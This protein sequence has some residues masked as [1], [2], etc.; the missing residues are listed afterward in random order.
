MTVTVPKICRHH[1]H[2]VLSCLH[3]PRVATRQQEHNPAVVHTSP[4]PGSAPGRCPATS[5]DPP[6]ASEVDTTSPPS[7]RG[8]LL[9]QRP[10][11]LSGTS[12]TMQGVGVGDGMFWKRRKARCLGQ[13]RGGM[14]RSWQGG[15]A[16]HQGLGVW[17][18][19]AECWTRSSMRGAD[20]GG[21]ED[22]VLLLPHCPR[23]SRAAL[24]APTLDPQQL[25]RT[26]SSP[27]GQPVRSRAWAKAVSFSPFLPELPETRSPCARTPGAPNRG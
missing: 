7:P 19:P 20:S 27:P 25:P 14:S 12:K 13:E 3:R 9:A 26:S 22:Q 11:P 16:G 2:L 23:R 17:K 24:A 8:A 21:R 4:A 1:T 15:R 5:R 18:Q 6:R 10:S